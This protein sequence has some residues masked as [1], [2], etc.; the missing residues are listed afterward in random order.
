MSV[1]DY[2]VLV[3]RESI[4]SLTM[5]Q[6]EDL[7]FKYNN[8]VFPEVIFSAISE[9]NSSDI[10]GNVLDFEGFSD[11]VKEVQEV[12]D[13]QLIEVEKLMDDKQLEHIGNKFKKNFIFWED[14]CFA[15][16]QEALMQAEREEID[17][18]YERSL[19]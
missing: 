2:S 9:Y 4:K 17:A 6:L 18:D 12:L 5:S 19:V 3:S 1:K 15:I 7:F 14:C 8:K 11:I 16:S 13:G 10:L